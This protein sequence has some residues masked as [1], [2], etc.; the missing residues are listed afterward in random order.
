MYLKSKP[1]IPKASLFQSDEEESDIEPISGK[2]PFPPPGIPSEGLIEATLTG[3]PYPIK[4]WIIWGTNTI[5]T[6]PASHRTIEALK[7]LDFVLAVDQ[8]PNDQTLFADIILPQCTYLER[9]DTVYVGKD[10]KVPYI[11]VRQPMMEPLYESRDPY[12]ITKQLTERLGYSCIGCEMCV[13]A[14]PYG[15]RY[16]DYTLD[17]PKADKCTFCMERVEHGEVPACVKTCLSEARVFGDLH[18]KKSEVYDLVHNKGA[19]RLTS[20]EVDIGP[21][22]YYIGNPRDLHLLKE[23]CTP[24]KMNA[25]RTSRRAMLAGLHK[26]GGNLLAGAGLFGAVAGL[27]D[28]TSSDSNSEQK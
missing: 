21:N 17:E 16:M 2:W 10:V 5:Q 27:V 12:W 15:A 1:P 8:I 28:L 6:I 4:S 11:S 13:D 3:K 22:V 25:G 19:I 9:Y 24:H 14:C 26:Q 18:D 23:T 7:K 20:S